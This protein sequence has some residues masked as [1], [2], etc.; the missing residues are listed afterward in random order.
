MPRLC[1]KCRANL[2]SI[3]ARDGKIR[4]PEC[5]ALLAL[6]RPRTD[7]RLQATPSAGPRSAKIERE[8]SPSRRADRDRP[9]RS[10]SKPSALPTALI[11]L[12]IGL[13]LVVLLVLGGGLAVF[14]YFSG[15]ASE[16]PIV[17]APPEAP[18]PT[19]PVAH[20]D[21][22]P[23]K[24]PIQPVPPEQRA[25]G[26]ND[27]LPLKELKA[28]TVYIKGETTTL[29]SRGSG[30]V[31]RAQGDTVL[32]ATNHHVI[33]PPKDEEGPLPPFFVPRGPRMPG[34]MRPPRLPRRGIVP[35]G[36]SILE[37]TVIFYSGTAK[38]QSLPAVVV[39]DDAVN[40]LAI[41]RAK[42]VADAPRPI[43]FQQTPELRETM[44]V[45]AF[46][47]PFGEKLDLQKKNPA[48]TV[49]KGAISSLR[50]EGGQLEQVQLDLDLN[51]GNSGGP[52]VDEKG[53]LIGVAVAKVMNTRIG[54]AVPVP[55][56]HR[57]MQGPLD[58]PVIAANPPPAARP[59]QPAKPAPTP[60]TAPRPSRTPKGEEL[61]KLLA[62]LKSPNEAVRQRAAS[63][64]QQA[65][66]RQRREEVRRGLQ[67][68]LAAKDPATRI[69]AVLALSACDPKEAAPSL[70]KMLAD[71]A[72]EVRQAAVKSLKLLRDP[73]VVEA[74][75]ARIPV[76]PLAVLDLLKAL[77]PAAE[78]AV[79]PYL[80]DKYAGPA[81]FWTFNVLNDIGTADSLPALERVQG[82]DSL[83]ARNT[84]DAIRGRLPLTAGEW[85]SAL[86]D[87]RSGDPMRRA[88][89]VRRIAATPP[90]AERR[91]DVVARLEGMLNDRFPE[92]CA[93]AAKG[94][95]RWAGQAAIP[96]LAKQMEGFNP[97]MH[98][99]A[100]DVLAEMKSDE[101]AAAIAKRLPDIHDRAKVV[102]ALKEMDAKVAEKVV[103]PFLDKTDVF[104]RVEA[105]KVLA[106]VGGR[107]SIAPLEKLANDNNVFYSNLARQAVETIKD[108][109]DEDAPI[110]PLR[111]T[112]TSPSSKAR[113]ASSPVKLQG[114]LAYW[115]FDEGEG[116]RAKHSSSNGLHAKVV[117]ASWRDGV[118]GKALRLIG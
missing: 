114:L 82:V 46:G 102:Q 67:E 20:L 15:S 64:L 5:K 42:G 8:P 37:L 36:A 89:A 18:P 22:E 53:A 74:A 17:S 47:F 25:G 113:E 84:I 54:F 45:V 91:A 100:I 38:E 66:P 27:T 33:T 93:A 21:P 108:R 76:E 115:N 92:V 60:V 52:V 72:Q 101:A 104:V 111:K 83:H 58:K 94:L 63:I 73:R 56:L 2:D 71:D 59:A 48:V 105:V 98:A 7:D 50:G 49:T 80:D 31:V 95:G 103:L 19:V 29:A 26:A 118:R 6:G 87:L 68:L 28:A 13:G 90:S 70:A 106:D 43:N 11:L 16:T 109:L 39:A 57:L 112:Q 32:V 69:A 97:P 44:S 14:L 117:H 40:D 96:L 10:K 81:R 79:L 85:S 41:L 30:F 75:A 55:K 99:E 107:D 34:M 61:T 110:T 77:G 116:E 1:P 23:A 4:C 12:G 35:P 51:P 24:E 3:P 88:R 78:K 9:V 62:D 65:P 86:D